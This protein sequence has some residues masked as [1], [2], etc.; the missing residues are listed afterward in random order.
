MKTSTERILK[1]VT[2]GGSRH[3]AL[4]HFLPKDWQLV[5]VKQLQ[6]GKGSVTIQI[7]RIAVE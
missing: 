4:T 1:V 5:K 2:Q 7:N 6:S 3:L